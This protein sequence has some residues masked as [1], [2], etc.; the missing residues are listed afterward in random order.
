VVKLPPPAWAFL[1]LIAAGALSWMYPWR[2]LTDLRIVWLG[3][4]L[5]AIGFPI[6]F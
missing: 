5:I 4:A 2:R 3:V 1:Y 6:A